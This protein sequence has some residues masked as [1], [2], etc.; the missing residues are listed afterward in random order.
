VECRC[1]M[2]EE[3]HGAMD[4]DRGDA[5]A[6]LLGPRGDHPGTAGPGEMTVASG[7][8]EMAKGKLNPSSPGNT[9]T[10]PGSVGKGG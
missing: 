10:T 3:H 8:A 2:A 7:A 1:A 9:G 6:Q 5:K 4:G